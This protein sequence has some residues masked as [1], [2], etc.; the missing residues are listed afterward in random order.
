MRL[1]IG[2]A[3]DTLRRFREEGA[4]FDFVY[5]D[6]NKREYPEYYGLVMDMLAPGGWILADNVLWDGKLWQDPMPQ[7]AQTLAIHRFNETVAGDPRVECTMIPVRD[8]LYLIRK[9]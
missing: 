4:S 6:A 3:K 1:H 9:K 7:D 8:G 2:D 5:M